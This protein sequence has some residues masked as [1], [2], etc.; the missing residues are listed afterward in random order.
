[1]LGASAVA[2]MAPQQWTQPVLKRVVTPAHGQAFSIAAGTYTFTFIEEYGS[3][4]VYR[5]T[6]T[7]SWPGGTDTQSVELTVT[8]VQQTVGNQDDS[9]Y[10]VGD[11]FPAPVRI[12]LPGDRTDDEWDTDPSSISPPLPGGLVFLYDDA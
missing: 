7:L 5:V 8:A 1:M 11:E 3:D 4:E 6:V 12:A 9:D 10:F 2:T